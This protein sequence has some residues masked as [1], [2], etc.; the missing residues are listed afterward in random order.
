M[1]V[2]RGDP[3][4]LPDSV[5]GEFLES[6]RVVV[7]ARLSEDGRVITANAEMA[8]RFGVGRGQLEGT[9]LVELLTEAEKPRMKVW[10]NA[11]DPGNRALGSDERSSGEAGPREPSLINFVSADLAVFTLRCLVYLDGTDRILIGEPDIHEDRSITDELLRLN[12]ELSV[13]SRENARRSRELEAAR[14]EL[15]ETLAELE[16]S[17]WHL[18][19]IRENLPLCM[20][21]GRMNTGDD[22]WES[23]LDYLRSNGILV[24]HGYCPSCAERL[25]SEDGPV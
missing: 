24:S 19:K 8:R 25:L 16:T 7:W 11:W 23:L 15:A 4:A 12:N 20:E 3:S 1:A 14:R 2:S 9:P 13:L 21:C 6:S 18:R 5:A 17:H 22:G 10:L